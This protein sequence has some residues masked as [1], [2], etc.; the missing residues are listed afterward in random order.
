MI[1]ATLTTSVRNLPKNVTAIL[2]APWSTNESQPW[3]E[4]LISRWWVNL[5]NLRLST[6][7]LVLKNTRTDEVILDKGGKHLLR[8]I[9]SRWHTTNVISS[10]WLLVADMHPVVQPLVLKWSMSRYIAILGA[11]FVCLFVYCICFFC[12]FVCF[13]NQLVRC[14][15]RHSACN[16]M[17]SGLRGLELV[18]TI[19]NVFMRMQECLWSHYHRTPGNR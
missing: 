5:S 12:Y 10:F 18:T 15:Y 7:S 11:V 13:I 4:P 1:Q 14:A 6:T 17:R 3:P 16:I 2:T 8:L 19:L 9:C